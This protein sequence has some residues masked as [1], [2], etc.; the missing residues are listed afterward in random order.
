MAAA[1]HPGGV[2]ALSGGRRGVPSAPSI[3][4]VRR[5]ARRLH[6][7]RAR[8]AAG[9]A[10]RRCSRS[11]ARAPAAASIGTRQRSSDSG[12][13]R[14][15]SRGAREQARA[16]P[17]RA[18]TSGSNRA[19]PSSARLSN[20]SPS[21]CRTPSLPLSLDSLSRPPRGVGDEATGA[22]AAALYLRQS[23]PRLRRTRRGGRAVRRAAA[24]DGRRHH[25]PRSS[26]KR[27]SMARTASHTSPPS[28][29]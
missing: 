3:A 18:A 19:M 24:A 10:A 28:C 4:V 27:A 25:A 26:T 8:G 16:E 11:P 9:T 22:A 20:K 6:C 13:G 5:R 7:A 15:T 29:G 17:P 2:D 12:G 23:A 1:P 14:P 21:L